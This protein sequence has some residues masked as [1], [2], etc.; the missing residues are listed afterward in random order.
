MDQPCLICF[1]AVKDEMNENPVGCPCRLFAHRACL[2]EWFT[3]KQQLEC[4]ICHTVFLPNPLQAQLQMIYVTV[5]EVARHQREQQRRRNR[6]QWIMLGC[7]VVLG[8]AGILAASF[9]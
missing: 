8:G 4:P 1:E 9:S 2:D 7:C 6:D 3:Q 5:S